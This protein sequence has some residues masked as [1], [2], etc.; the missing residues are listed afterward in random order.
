MTLMALV[1]SIF[2][3]CDKAPRGVIP[4]SDMAHVLADFAKA[5]A[6][7]DQYPDKFPDDSSRLAL[8]QSIL[9]KYD[10]DLEKYDSS[11]VWYAHNLKL[12]SELHEKAVTILEK[13]ANIKHSNN[14][15]GD[16]WINNAPG[17]MP[18]VGTNVRR[19]FPS[20][21]D[22]ANI[23]KE[24]QQWILTSAMRKGYI[25][26]DYK[27]DNESRPGDLYSL[28]FKS[29]NASQNVLKILLAI[30]Y[31]DKT[32]SYINRTA[33][34]NGW[35]NFDIQS[36]STRRIERIYGYI[37]YD[38]QPHRVTFIDSIYLLRTRLDP[39]LYNHI[40][41]QRIAGPKAVLEKA[42]EEEQQPVDFNDRPLPG[43]SSDI[44]LPSGPTGRPTLPS[45]NPAGPTGRPSPATRRGDSTFRPKPGLN[46]SVIPSRE[47]TPNPNGAHTPKPP[48][49]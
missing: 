23:W 4:E 42:K 24:P 49:K 45:T 31:S 30:D 33:N 25:T 36:D 11:L 46:K 17:A 40:N 35:S 3:G 1:A 48:I 37:Y 32:T 28:N 20:T 39:T 7:I 41:I 38:I 13:E 27:P 10:A 47:R 34:I 19:V 18:S 16:T 29:L 8:K 5:E 43:R 15:A 6:I 26:Y 14:N 9:K 44:T 22:S 12:Y 21:G 2:M